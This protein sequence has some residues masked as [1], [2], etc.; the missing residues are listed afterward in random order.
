MKL[1]NEQQDTLQLLAWLHLQCG[2]PEPARVL[3]EVLLR[4]DPQHRAAGRA[5]VVAALA[6]GDWAWA[7]QQCL[8]LRD[9][10]ERQPSLWLCLS[11]AQQ[12]A[13]R[14][15][16]AQATYAEYQRRKACP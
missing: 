11:Q 15:E 13:G 16:Q 6:L 9:A 4:A 5:A 14:L 7:E 12:L 1:S 10:G 2:R 8:A 3:L